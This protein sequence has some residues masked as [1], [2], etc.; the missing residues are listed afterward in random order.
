MISD[1]VRARARGEM[2]FEDKRRVDAAWRR[3]R[4]A[5]KS[6]L[7]E[8]QHAEQT[9]QIQAALAEG[10]R[11]VLP[12]SQGD[13]SGGWQVIAVEEKGYGYTAIAISDSRCQEFVGSP[14]TWERLG[15]IIGM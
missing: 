14:D 7:A 11:L 9:A 5:V 13:K 6:V 2:S 8:W 3:E 4:R 10:A 12:A 15:K 1:L